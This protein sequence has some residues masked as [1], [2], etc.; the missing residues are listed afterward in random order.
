[1]RLFSRNTRNCVAIQETMAIRINVVVGF[2]AGSVEARFKGGALD[3][4]LRRACGGAKLY[5]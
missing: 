3:R 5:R 2:V 4:V 1:M